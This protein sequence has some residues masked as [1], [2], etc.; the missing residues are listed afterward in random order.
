MDKLQS[1]GTYQL[2]G[3]LGKFLGNLGEVDCSITIRGDQGAGKSQL[4]W[5]LVDAFAL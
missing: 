2:Q 4:M 3:D 5:Q 1:G